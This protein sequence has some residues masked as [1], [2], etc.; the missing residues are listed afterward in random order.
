[1]CAYKIFS[2]D[3]ELKSLFGSDTKPSLFHIALKQIN[4]EVCVTC[5]WSS[6]VAFECMCVLLRLELKDVH[7][8]VRAVFR[9]ATFV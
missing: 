7:V 4:Y 8:C 9:R 6:D 1:M 2:C 3:A 5:S